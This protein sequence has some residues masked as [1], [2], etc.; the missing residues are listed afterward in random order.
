MYAFHPHGALLMV[1]VQFTGSC[2]TTRNQKEKMAKS[3]AEFK[4]LR[5]SKYSYG[6][7]R[8]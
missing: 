6:T 8:L 2:G 5:L 7:K 4:F 1:T 3:L